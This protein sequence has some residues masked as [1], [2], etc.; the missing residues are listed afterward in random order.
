MK[1]K[2]HFLKTAFIYISHLDPTKPGGVVFGLKEAAHIA[3]G[4][5]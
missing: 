5:Q 4:Y 1:K 3:Y 2:T